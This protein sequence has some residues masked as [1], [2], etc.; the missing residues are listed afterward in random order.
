M[1]PI[2]ILG[3]LAFSGRQETF[4][5]IEDNDIGILWAN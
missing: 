2:A 1:V 3:D 4:C 5:E